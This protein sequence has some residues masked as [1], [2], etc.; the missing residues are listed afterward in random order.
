M[1]DNLSIN[2][3]T[4]TATAATDDVA[5]VH[6][7]RVKVVNGSDGGAADVAT[8]VLSSVAASAT[9]VPLLAA[10]P[11]R[12]SASVYNESTSVLYLALAA[13]ASATAYTVAIPASGYYELVA[14][15]YTGAIS[16]I[17]ASANGNA[18]ITEVGG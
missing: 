18:R 12:A 14:P 3:A 1:A 7:Q 9:S 6:F 2:T 10:N 16:G 13:T 17:W 11:D 8:A 4:G 5:G 15:A